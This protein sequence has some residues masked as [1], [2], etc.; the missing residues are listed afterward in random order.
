[1]FIAW[2][3]GEVNILAQIHFLQ[4]AADQGFVQAQLACGIPFRHGRLLERNLGVSARY[5]KAAAD[6]GSIELRWN[7]QVFLFAVMESRKIFKKAKNI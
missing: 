6:Q 1:M 3:W 4:Q 7:I 5:F 2:S